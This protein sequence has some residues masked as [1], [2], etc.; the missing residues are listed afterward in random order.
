MANYSPLGSRAGSPRSPKTP[1]TLQAKAAWW[2]AAASI[3]L[4]TFAV[5]NT[6]FNIGAPWAGEADDGHPHLKRVVLKSFLLSAG[7]S[8]LLYQSK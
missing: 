8:K 3:T 6:S 2:L 7:E 1:R 5:L 4:S